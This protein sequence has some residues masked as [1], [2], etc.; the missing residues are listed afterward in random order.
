YIPR[1]EIQHWF[2]SRDCDVPGCK[3]IPGD[4]GCHGSW[5]VDIRTA[6]DPRE[7]LKYACSPDAKNLDRAEFA[8]LR[9]LTYLVLYKRHRIETS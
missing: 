7:A 2:Q 6:F 9:L 3:H 1:E 8:E 4:R 5:A